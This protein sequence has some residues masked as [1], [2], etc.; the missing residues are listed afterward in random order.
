MLTKID[1]VSS[2]GIERFIARWRRYAHGCIFQRLSDEM[3]MVSQSRS[4]V[5]AKGCYVLPGQMYCLRRMHKALSR[6]RIECLRRD[7]VG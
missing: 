6:R 5:I 3:Q 1:D 4:I 7:K 2:F